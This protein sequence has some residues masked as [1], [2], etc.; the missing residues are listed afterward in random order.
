MLYYIWLNELFDS[1]SD[2]DDYLNKVIESFVILSLLF[3]S[4]LHCLHL[5]KLLHMLASGGF[6]VSFH[7]RKMEERIIRIDIIHSLVSIVVQVV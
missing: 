3:R 5:G 6:N 2:S 4:R 1:D 7:G